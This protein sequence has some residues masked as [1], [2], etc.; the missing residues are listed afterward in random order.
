MR[1]ILVSALFLVFGCGLITGDGEAQTGKVA[2]RGF[3]DD[4]EWRSFESGIKEAE[5]TSKP[6]LVVIHKSW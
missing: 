2:G 1:G 6:A 5:S 4:Y 3:G